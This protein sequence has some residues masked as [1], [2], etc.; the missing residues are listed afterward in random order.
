MVLIKADIDAYKFNYYSSFMFF[1]FFVLSFIVVL[2]L[3]IAIQLSK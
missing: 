3:L 1:S 2:M